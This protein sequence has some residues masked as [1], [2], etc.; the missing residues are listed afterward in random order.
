MKQ[1]FSVWLT[2]L[3]IALTSTSA[4]AQNN[5]GPTTL[6]A[7]DAGNCATA[8]ACATFT[9]FGEGASSITIDVTVS[10][11]TGVLTFEGTADGTTWRALQAVNLV[12]GSIGSTTTAAGAF[13]VINTGLAKVRVR[14]GTLSGGTATVY[15]LRGVALPIWSDTAGV[16]RLQVRSN[17]AVSNQATAS[18]AAVAGV[19][20]VADCVS[21]SAGSTTAPALTALTVNLRD[22]ATGAGTVIWSQQVI[23]PA[24]TGQN[25][26]PFSLCGLNLRGT[27]NT[28]MTL[29]FSALLT[30]LIESVSL[31]YYEL[32]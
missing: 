3:A 26:V 21:F 27:A 20:H 25:V 17:P 29:E 23:I 5:Q 31:T 4:A 10:G 1:Y 7:Q 22:G 15:A 8:N 13:S 24:A 28:A 19:R 14:A 30:N 32:R 18:A 11:F 9:Q 12:D 16:P 2:W 6:S